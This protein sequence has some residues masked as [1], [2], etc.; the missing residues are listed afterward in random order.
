MRRVLATLLL[1]LP[2]CQGG[3]PPWTVVSPAY[4]RS[5]SQFRLTGDVRH[6]DLE[7]GVYVIH[8]D[9]SVT[10]APTNLPAAFRREGLHVEADARRQE[11]A[12][13]IHQVGHVIEVLRIRGRP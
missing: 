4:T 5:I 6:L 9:D 12:V 8:G 11:Q 7:G 2:A 1:G 10:Y 3:L 13:G